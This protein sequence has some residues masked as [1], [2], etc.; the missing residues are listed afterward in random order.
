MKKD[1]PSISINQ[2][3]DEAI[4]MMA[5][6]EMVEIPVVDKKESIRGFSAFIK[7]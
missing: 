3:V 5:N 2:S 7:P 6:N 1:Y 4:E